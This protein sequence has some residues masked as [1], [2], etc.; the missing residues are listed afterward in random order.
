MSHAATNSVKEATNHGQKITLRP[1]L[2]FLGL[3]SFLALTPPETR[4]DDGTGEAVP[5]RIGW[6]IPAATQGQVLQ[7]LKRTSLLEMHGLKPVFVPFSYGGPQV[8]AAFAGQLDV[9]FAGDQPAF[10]LIARGAGGRHRRLG[11]DGCRC[12]MG[13]A[14]FTV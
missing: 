3:F 7:V 10:N 13:A 8:E 5:I 2:L 4:G 9:F 6:Q 1:L 14:H 11:G 12:R